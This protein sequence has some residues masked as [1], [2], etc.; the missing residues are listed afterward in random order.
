MFQLHKAFSPAEMVTQVENNCRSAAWG[1]V[2]CKKVLHGHMVEELTPI[3]R[4]AEALQAEPERVLDTLA[5]GAR[6]A[7]T[8]AQETMRDVRQKMGLDPLT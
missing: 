3:R 6:K 7:R 4:R 1:C 5:D 8:I 2:E